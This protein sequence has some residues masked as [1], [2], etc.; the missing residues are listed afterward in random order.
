MKVQ[1]L[2]AALSAQN[3]VEGANLDAEV[4]CGYSCDLL[5]WVLG[6]GKPGMAWITVQSHMNVIA[7]AVLLEMACVILPEGVELEEASLKKAQE[8]DLPVLRSNQTAFALSA[9]MVAAGIASAEE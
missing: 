4:S 5:S 6:H 8:E 3:V 2:M 9:M 1:A 7:V